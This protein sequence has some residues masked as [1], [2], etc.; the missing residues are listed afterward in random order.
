M[1]H[2]GEVISFRQEGS[3]S[4]CETIGSSKMGASPMVFSLTSVKPLEQ[5]H[6]QINTQ[7]IELELLFLL[8][9]ILVSIILKD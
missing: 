1:F 5:C 6:A 3:L 8:Y 7:Q 2:L 4:S 9:K